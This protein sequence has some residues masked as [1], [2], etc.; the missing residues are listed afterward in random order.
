MDERARAINRVT[1]VG[2]ISNLCLLIG[3]FIAG[4]IGNSGAMI[5]DAI[6]SLSDFVTDAIVLV[7]VNISAKPSDKSHDFG[8]GKFETLATTIIA[9]SLF[10]VGIGIIVKNAVIVADIVNGKVLPKP[11]IIAFI[12][13]A[14]SIVIKE[15]L[16]WYTYINGKRLNC[17]AVIANAWHHRSDALSSVATL[18]GIGCAYFIGNKWTI[19]DPIAAII[20]G[21]LIFKV[22]CDLFFPAINELLEKSLPEETENEILQIICQDPNVHDPHNLRTRNIGNHIAI[23][24]HIR[25]DAQMTVEQSHNITVNVEKQ[26]RIR[27]GEQTFITLHVEP[28]N[29]PKSI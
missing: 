22:A 19:M 29:L 23:E 27:F 11:G 6:H 8:H 10:I 15:A 25:L 17:S 2:G 3:K 18:A 9:L 4:I 13:A 5:A 7:F 20:V 16:Y 12:M 14:L 1:I 28:L 21:V 26:L 24:V